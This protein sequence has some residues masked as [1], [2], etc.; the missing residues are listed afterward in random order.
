VNHSVPP[1]C[2]LWADLINGTA[3][4]FSLLHLLYLILPVGLNLSWPPYGSKVS[5]ENSVAWVEVSSLNFPVIEDF[6]PCCCLNGCFSCNLICLLHPLLPMT[7]IILV[8]V[9]RL[10]PSKSEQQINGQARR[11]SKE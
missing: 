10:I 9:P 11:P 8:R 6:S 5:E 3:I 7:H 1:F 4:C 2:I